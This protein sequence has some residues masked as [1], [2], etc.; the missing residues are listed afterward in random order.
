MSLFDEISSLDDVRRLV[1][2]GVR[3][4]ETLE[5]KRADVVLIDDARRE[6][7]KDVSALANSAGGTLIYGVETERSGDRTV[8]TR[9]VPI[10]PTNIGR[11]Q[12]IISGDIRHPIPGVRTKAIP[13]TGNA[14]VLLVDVPASQLAPHQ[15]VIDNKYYRRHLDESVPMTHELVELYFGRRLGPW[16]GAELRAVRQNMGP[17]GD[18]WIAAYSCQL[19][20]RNDG[21]GSAREVVLAISPQE[22][23]RVSVTTGNS[24]SGFGRRA[25]PQGRTLE[26]R[27]V[28][29]DLVI[30][31]ED[32]AHL[33][34]FE[35]H[36]GPDMYANREN[37]RRWALR[38]S[39]MAANMRPRRFLLLVW[40]DDA[41]Q[42]L[43]IVDDDGS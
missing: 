35:V 10:D 29:L 3:E 19:W 6:V 18:D 34:S 22:R 32:D 25:S 30:H 8:P 40:W 11:I 33:H 39:V 31:P 38:L 17:L 20:L 9:I 28:P 7:A 42:G 12:R 1:T 26:L 43:Q 37:P 14:T 36:V 4:S 13:A 16:L 23:G 24:G 2:D 41:Q 27:A 21:S 5:Y 15:N